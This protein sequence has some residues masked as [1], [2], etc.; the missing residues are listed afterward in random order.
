[1]PTTSDGRR[2]VHTAPSVVSRAHGTRPHL[3]RPHSWPELSCPTEGRGEN[4]AV[5]LARQPDPRH[6]Y[7][8]HCPTHTR[9]WHHRSP[10][11]P[12]RCT[13][14]LQPAGPGPCRS[15]ARYTRTQGRIRAVPMDGRT[16][17]GPGPPAALVGTGLPS[18]GP[19]VSAEAAQVPGSHR[20]APHGRP[21]GVSSE[22]SSPR[23]DTGHWTQG[24]PSSGVTSP[25]LITSANPTSKRGGLHE[26]GS[27]GVG[28]W[29]HESAQQRSA[30]GVEGGRTPALVPRPRPLLPPPSA[31]SST[32]GG[33]PSSHTPLGA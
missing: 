24:P 19:R 16:G 6:R 21:P 26:P 22:M 12:G 27:R 15:A 11:V 25:S 28:T 30:L 32:P 31:C 29:A 7:T 18:W 33:V 14:T 10:A 4:A 2:S 17:Q 20:P 1:M 9:A 8:N 5:P 3:L 13:R 23:T